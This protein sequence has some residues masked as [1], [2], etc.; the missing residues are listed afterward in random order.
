M[1]PIRVAIVDDEALVRSGLRMIV[2]GSP[3]I[4]CV[5]EGQ[6]GRDAIQL[7]PSCDVLLLDIRMPLVDGIQALQQIV[8]LIDAPK[9]IMLTAFDT[10]QNILTTMKYGAVGFLL[11]TTPP[12]QLVAAV[13]AAAAGQTIVTGSVMSKLVE[14]AGK[15]PANPLFAML[16]DREKEIAGLVAKGLTNDE[17]AK[18]LF[19]SLST[20]KTHIAR[21]MDKL[22]CDNRVKIAIIALEAQQA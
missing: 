9:V 18:Q 3:N 14:K 5:G 1:E 21:I 17:I 15:K 20:V 12:R 7:A 8:Q 2:E 6:N 4:V 16:S 13:Q 11:K 22:G 10:D 19:V